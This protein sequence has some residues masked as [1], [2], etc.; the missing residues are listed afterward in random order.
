MLPLQNA[1]SENDM[2]IRRTINSYSQ[3]RIAC[4]H[5][6]FLLFCHAISESAAD[7]VSLINGT[8]NVGLLPKCKDSTE[9]LDVVKRICD[10]Y[11]E[12]IKIRPFLGMNSDIEN[13][14][15]LANM[16]LESGLFAGIEL[17]GAGFAENPEK[18]IAIFNTARRLGLDSRICCLGFKKFKNLDSIYETIQN[19]RPTLVLNPNFA[20]GDEKVKIFENKKLRP[21][22]VKFF[23]DE[24]ISMEFSP[25]LL[26]SEKLGKE[27]I[28]SIREFA[29][30]DIPFSFCTEDMLFLNKSISEFAADLCRMGVFSKE[31]MI[32]L[33][34]D[35][36][37]KA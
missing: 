33:I 30:N 23:K 17:Y 31:E 1:G 34:S 3:M 19:L 20:L 32:S 14:L 37:S 10:K 36:P 9:F 15:P 7:N 24:K 26:F 8:V 22:A 13:N 12:T 28:L 6:I 29:E 2:Q 27:K 4:A 16:L 11:S 21:E 5:D 35:K 25:F 18:F